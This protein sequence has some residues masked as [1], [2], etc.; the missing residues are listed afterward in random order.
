VILGRGGKLGE[1]HQSITE[2]HDKL[3]NEHK[4][5]SDQVINFIEKLGF[6]DEADQ[7]KICLEIN[8]PFFTILTNESLRPYIDDFLK[9]YSNMLESGNYGWS[10]AETIASNMRQIFKNPDVNDKTRSRA[11]EFA[12]DAAIMMNRF[13]AMDTCVEMITSVN[14]DELGVHVSA[15]LQK[16]RDSFINS[17]EPS[18]CKCESIRKVLNA[19]NK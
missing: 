9:I 10:F 17:I 14:N 6:L 19:L 16:N 2:I 13:A 15:V 1:V 4:Y 18:Q 3:E 7:I 5:N 11:L 8:Q 12:I